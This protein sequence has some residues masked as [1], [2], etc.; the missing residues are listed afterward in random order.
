MASQS[1]R[2][3]N[4]ALSSVGFEPSMAVID[5]K[6][7]AHLVAPSM[8]AIFNEST[9]LRDPL[10]SSSFIMIGAADGRLERSVPILPPPLQ[11]TCIY[12]AG[13]PA[14]V[15]GGDGMGSSP[16]RIWL[17]PRPVVAV[18]RPSDDW[19]PVVGDSQLA[20]QGHTKVDPPGAP[21]I[22]SLA[23]FG[24]T[25][26]EQMLAISRT[27]LASPVAYV[28][29]H[30]T[31]HYFIRGGVPAVDAGEENEDL[32]ETRLTVQSATATAFSSAGLPTPVLQPPGQRMAF[33]TA[34]FLSDAKQAAQDLPRPSSAVGRTMARDLEYLEGTIADRSQK[35]SQVLR[36]VIERLKGGAQGGQ[37]PGSALSGTANN[38]WDLP[39]AGSGGL[40]KLTVGMTPAGNIKFGRQLLDTPQAHAIAALAD[41]GDTASATAYAYL[42][43]NTGANRARVDAAAAS[44]NGAVSTGGDRLRTALAK[45]DIASARSVVDK[46]AALDLIM[47]AG[48]PS[49][50]SS[51]LAADALPLLRKA[52]AGAGLR[53]LA[54]THSV[55]S[56]SVTTLMALRPGGL[57]VVDKAFLRVLRDDIIA[58]DCVLDG[59]ALR[60]LLSRVHAAIMAIPDS[61]LPLAL[62]ED[63]VRGLGGRIAILPTAP[64]QGGADEAH[65]PE[66]PSP[67]EA[68][69]VEKTGWISEALLAPA[70]RLAKAMRRA[71]PVL[72]SEA[73]D[74]LRRGV[75]TG[76]PSWD[77]G[78]YSSWLA[79]RGL[80]LPAAD[81]VKRVREW[82]VAEEEERGAVLHRKAH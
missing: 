59:S 81:D 50:A 43:R 71:W 18:E 29:L 79:A 41:A 55:A 37:R 15:E 26:T 60:R 73:L 20:P 8:P 57:G 10:G 7:N 22:W 72:L 30:P 51:V 76:G 52:S 77:D 75:E 47:S 21:E 3:V 62:M 74:V 68:A 65:D 67:A 11:A 33:L 54:G 80:V 2:R 58:G 31:P 32:N 17:R 78:Y 19:K 63:R 9:R 16:R 48:R 13:D 1:S 35:P 6:G 5:R 34:T 69:V 27:P 46:A 14:T 42:L 44:F 12:D 66:E 49:T 56:Q 24:A 64:A 38:I 39:P 36:P 23:P 25:L 28:R 61:A 82:H 45:H 4:A 70:E 40:P 53:R